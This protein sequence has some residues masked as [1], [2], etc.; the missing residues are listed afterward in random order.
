MIAMEA[1]IEKQGVTDSVKTPPPNLKH[2]VCPCQGGAEP[3][4]TRCGLERAGKPGSLS[5]V[6]LY[7]LCVVCQDLA[8]SGVPCTF[9]GRV[10]A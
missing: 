3:G 1:V 7:D 4:F 5:S 10:A 2:R 9:C 8:T 6:K